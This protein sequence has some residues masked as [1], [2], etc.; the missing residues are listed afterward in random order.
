MEEETKFMKS[1]LP[2]HYTCEPRNDGVHCYSNIGIDENDPEHFEYIFL[3]IKQKFKKRFMEVYHQ[4][5]T[6]HK[7]FT[8]YIRPE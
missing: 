7:K 5:C 2:D 3:A 8:V 6:D 4:T 1:L